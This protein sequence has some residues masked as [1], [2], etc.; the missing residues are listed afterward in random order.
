MSSFY[1]LWS[2]ITIQESLE[3]YYVEFFAKLKS[4]PGD[5]Y[6]HFTD[7]V[8]DNIPKGA[9]EQP[10]IGINPRN[11]GGYYGDPTGVYAFP[12]DYVLSD[13]GV[14]H[15]FY[16]KKYIYIIQLKPGQRILNLTTITLPEAEGVAANLGLT[17]EF[18]ATARMNSGK[19]PGKILWT[20]FIDNY[21]KNKGGNAAF[22]N[23][24][25][26]AGYDAIVDDGSGIIHH[27]EKN[28]IAILNPRG[29]RVLDMMKNPIRSGVSQQ[30]LAMRILKIV[31]TQ[32]LGKYSLTT[33]RSSRSEK[34]YHAKGRIKNKP[35]TVYLTQY[36][37]GT[38][39]RASI[40]IGSH[41]MD[42]YI[43]PF[44]II[45]P[46]DTYFDVDNEAKTI[47]AAINAKLEKTQIRS[48]NKKKVA[49]LANA[50][51]QIMGFTKMPELD[52]ESATLT[53][54]YKK[55]KFRFNVRYS[56]GKYTLHIRLDTQGL[57]AVSMDGSSEIPETALEGDLKS[58]AKMYLIDTLDD[59]E[60]R[61]Y[62]LYNPDEEAHKDRAMSYTHAEKG[63]R[64]L[65]FLEF[66]RN[67]F[68]ITVS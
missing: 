43:K 5:V 6:V 32:V 18:A 58:I 9:I 29:Y 13:L 38:R 57:Y 63:K 64:M 21:K 67:K 12:R 39:F 17:Y 40:G 68:S 47:A 20:T 49:D 3:D 37:E 28:Q 26:R 36:E 27:N 22:N 55:G 41:Y 54:R 10:K 48:S 65:D 45:V 31:A 7:G 23:A 14:N 11:K 30:R 15:F 16:S 66:I 56:M 8:T 61:T 24:V 2:K 35:F 46:E 19:E 33:S 1:N 53:R 59:L 34:T 62:Q 4:Y 50:L 44:T 42:S 52:E 25:R 60:K 51:A